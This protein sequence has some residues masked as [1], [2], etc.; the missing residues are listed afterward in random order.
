ME[1]RA[2]QQDAGPTARTAAVSHLA[3]SRALLR[4]ATMGA[5]EEAA[6]RSPRSLS[7]VMRAPECRSAARPL[8]TTSEST[9]RSRPDSCFALAEQVPE[10]AGPAHLVLVLCEHV[11]GGGGPPCSREGDLVREQ[12]VRRVHLNPRRRAFRPR[13]AAPARA[14]P[15]FA[16]PSDGFPT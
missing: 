7:S 10:A 15:E 11:A 2:D 16:R 8:R 5:G 3:R 1:R 12:R 6:S 13:R 9:D 4:P 14:D